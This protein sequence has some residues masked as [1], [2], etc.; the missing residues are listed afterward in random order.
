[1][2]WSRRISMLWVV[3][4]GVANQPHAAATGAGAI[5]RNLRSCAAM[6]VSSMRRVMK[7]DGPAE[8]GDP[9]RSQLDAAHESTLQAA[10]WVRECQRSGMQLHAWRGSCAI[11]HI[12]DDRMPHTCQMHTQ[13][14]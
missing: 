5:L 13:L 14:V 6:A 7:P 1:M 9:R 12:T 10:S 2:S 4:S 11:Q 3:A 8:D